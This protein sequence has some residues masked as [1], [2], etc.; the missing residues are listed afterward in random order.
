MNEQGPTAVVTG[1]GSG[2]GRAVALA[3]L[4][5]ATG[6]CSPAGAGAP[7][8]ETAGGAG[9][10]AL[11]V[12]PTSRTRPR[13]T[14]CSPPGDASG[15]LDLLFNNAGTRATGVPLDELTVEQWRAVVDIN[16]TGASSAPGR[17][18]G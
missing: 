6:S 16:L 7:L 8:E 15:R 1:A 14:R 17:R 10:R 9:G 12:P 3:L 5:A 4:D 2:I 18:S 13:S 11:V